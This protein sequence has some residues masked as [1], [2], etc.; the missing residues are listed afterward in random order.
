MAYLT[1]KRSGVTFPIT[2][3]LCGEN[4]HHLLVVDTGICS[5]SF[6]DNSVHCYLYKYG[7]SQQFRGKLLFHAG[8]G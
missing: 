7:T 1:S 2:L 4:Q 8:R 5:V 6:L 3:R